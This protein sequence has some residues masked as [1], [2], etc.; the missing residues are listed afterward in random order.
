VSV[1]C[2]IIVAL[3]LIVQ[4]DFAI[5]VDPA[6]QVMKMLI[7]NRAANAAFATKDAA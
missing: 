4:N 6:M 1:A 7:Y 3:I 2:P 5:S